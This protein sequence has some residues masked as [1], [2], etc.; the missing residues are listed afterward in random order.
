MV[1][2]GWWA[3]PGMLAQ[4]GNAEATVIQPSAVSAGTRNSLHVLE[5]ATG[6]QHGELQV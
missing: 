3:E 5:S 4:Q 1:A 6:H 2:V